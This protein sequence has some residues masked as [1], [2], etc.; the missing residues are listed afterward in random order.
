MA[1]TASYDTDGT[2]RCDTA[3]IARYDIDG[4]ARCDARVTVA[5]AGMMPVVDSDPESSTTKQQHY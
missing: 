5:A 1:V 4:T 2:A 3:V